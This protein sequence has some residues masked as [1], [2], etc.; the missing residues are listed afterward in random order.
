MK[1]AKYVVCALLVLMLLA[2]AF[3]GCAK[4]QGDTGETQRHSSAQTQAETAEKKTE[5]VEITFLGAADDRGQKVFETAFKDL[6]KEIPEVVLKTQYYPTQQEVAK[7]IPASVASGTA[8]DIISV[9]NEGA[10]EYIVNGLV[11]PMDE[12]APKAGLDLQSRYSDAVLN[13]WRYEGKLYGIPTTVGTSTFAV[14]LDMWEKAGL[15]ELPQTFDEVLAAAQKLTDKNAG[16]YGICVNIDQFHITQYIHAFGGGWGFGKSI[17]SPENEKGLQFFVDL[18]TKY[19]VAVTPNQLGLGWDGEVFAK[20]KAAMSTGGPWYKGLLTESA[21]DMKYKL[22]PIPKGT[23]QRPILYGGGYCIMEGAKNKEL[24]MKVINYMERDFAVEE[25]LKIDGNIPAV[26]SIVPKYIELNPDMKDIVDKA[27]SDG[28]FFNY[29]LD[30]TR[31]F[32]ELTKGVEEV[33]F[34]PGSKTVKQLLDELQAKF[35]GK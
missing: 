23:A 4:S 26:S 19:Q 7:I 10:F 29:P 30:S 15:G 8:P 24:A 1:K 25:R 34:K 22:L 21:P 6:E 13:T 11:A 35:A 28:V 12:L 5:P 27:F 14:N 17:N 3:S 33:I 32:S 2:S 18:Y 20:G 9:T 31:F 16:V